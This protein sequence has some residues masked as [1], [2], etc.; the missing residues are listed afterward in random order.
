MID[1]SRS[2][3][4]LPVPPNM[5]DRDRLLLNCPKGTIDLRTGEL[6]THYT[7][8]LISRIIPVCNKPDAEGSTWL[9][10]LDRIC[11]R[12][13]EMIRYLQHIASNHELVINGTDEGIWSR[14]KLIPFLET[15]PEEERGPRLAE[16]LLAEA[17][18]NLAWAV[19]GCLEWQKY[20]L[21]E[22]EMARR[23]TAESREE[24]DSVGEFLATCCIFEPGANIGARVLFDTYLRWSHEAGRG[25]DVRKLFSRSL[26]ERGIEKRKRSGY[27]YI[28]LGLR[29][30]AGE[31]SPL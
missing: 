28:G 15:I 1:L 10:F 7:A 26:A 22:P 3:P 12:K 30:D 4:G 19:E 20:G 8:D 29:E 23:A 25:Q 16:K 6:R 21:Y 9:G 24:S 13:P 11:S 14:V 27:H 5:L 31:T 2:E 17:E 18:G